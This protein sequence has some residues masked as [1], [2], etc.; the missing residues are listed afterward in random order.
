M[1]STSPEQTPFPFWN[2]SSVVN[3]GFK[4]TAKRALSDVQ[5]SNKRSKAQTSVATG[6]TGR[7]KSKKDVSANVLWGELLDCKVSELLKQQKSFENRLQI[8]EVE[9]RRLLEITKQLMQVKIVSRDLQGTYVKQFEGN[10]TAD[11]QSHSTADFQGNSRADFQGNSRADFQ[12]NSRADF[13][14]NSRVDFQSYSTADFHSTADFQGL[15]FYST[16]MNAG[17]WNP[18]E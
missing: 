11:F 14:G 2:P 7:R 16:S 1:A 12:G 8:L 5:G 6:S 4:Q 13:Q 10:S 15:Q 18:L 9:N 3:A 17:A